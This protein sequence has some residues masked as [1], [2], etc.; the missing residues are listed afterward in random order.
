MTSISSTISPYPRCGIL[1]E[2][3]SKMIFKEKKIENVIIAQL[4]AV[5]SYAQERFEFFHDA[6]L[7]SW[8]T[9]CI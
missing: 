5:P 3:S 7:Q 8:T 1:A 2:N 6:V 9:E 4:F